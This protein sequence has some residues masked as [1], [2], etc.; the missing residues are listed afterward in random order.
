MF[1]NLK[2]VKCNEGEHFGNL[3]IS[4]RLL[5]YS[6]TMST[7]KWQ[8]T[9]GKN[10]VIH[11]CHVIYF[12]E[13]RLERREIFSISRKKK[14]RLISRL[15]AKYH[16]AIK[17]FIVKKCEKPVKCL[18]VA[19]INQPQQYTRERK[20]MKYDEYE[21]IFCTHTSSHSCH[22]NLNVEE[23]CAHT[24]WAWTFSKVT[25]I[26]VYTLSKASIFSVAL[27]KS[28]RHN[29]PRLDDTC[30]ISLLLILSALM[31]NLEIISIEILRNVLCAGRCVRLHKNYICKNSYTI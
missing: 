22:I 6:I 25:I 23:L 28:K 10:E 1:A 9:R 3:V 30:Y 4:A 19:D 16:N 15:F 2:C 20:S 26:I 21:N 29:R 17:T 27:T 24:F 12:F 13:K 14:N 18:H 31:H 11:Q 5:Y 7:I 8:M